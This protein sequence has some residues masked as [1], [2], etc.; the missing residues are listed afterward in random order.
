MPATTEDFELYRGEDATLSFLV[1]PSEDIT[2][3]T[4]LFTMAR[5]KNSPSKLYE[6]ECV[7]TDE[8]GGGYDA[9][10]PGADSADFSPA[11]YWYDA[12]RTDE[13]FARLLAIGRVLVKP[14]VREPEA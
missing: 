13:G 9:V 12:W 3:W 5:S 4:I 6:A 10:L 2:G 11:N 7:H 1:D 14:N 8:A